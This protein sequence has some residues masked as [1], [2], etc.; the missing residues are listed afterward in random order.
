[1][2]KLRGKLPQRILLDTSAWFAI[3]DENDESHIMATSFANENPSGWM[4]TDL[5]ISELL[6]LVIRKLGVDAARR[7]GERIFDKK[8]TKI[9]KTP[10]TQLVQAWELFREKGSKST[11]FVDCAL[12]VVARQTKVRI[13]TFDDDFKKLGCKIVP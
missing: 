5:V 9:L 7:V 6:N 12:A 8:T 11:S 3:S 13:F 10:K 1:M 2:K 4:T